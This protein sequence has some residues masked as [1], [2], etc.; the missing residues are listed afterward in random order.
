MTPK[1]SWTRCGGGILAAAT[2]AFAMGTLA[3]ESDAKADARTY[4]LKN[5]KAKVLGTRAVDWTIQWWEWAY[6][7]PTN[8]HPLFDE[9]GEFVEVGQR[10]PVW[11]LG[12]IFNESGTA[13]RTA[14]IP[15]GKSLFFPVLNV[16][17][18][19][20]GADPAMDEEELRGQA[21]DI[22]GLIVPGSMDVSVDGVPIVGLET[23]RIAAGPFRYVLPEGNV[24]QYFGLIAP[25]GIYA[26]IASD[27]YWVMLRPLSLGQHTIHIGGTFGGAL[28][29]TLD[30]T[31][32]LTVVES[33]QP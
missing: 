3:P 17:M 29:F 19:N 27:G 1:A 8:T 33:N 5:G 20:I 15:A 24:Q 30:V 6:S 25:R 13:V 2:L 23:G 11:F 14:T 31:Y 10:G 28:N 7:I 4:A 16:E 21:A 26:P 22:V 9:T 18:S 12:G 32:N